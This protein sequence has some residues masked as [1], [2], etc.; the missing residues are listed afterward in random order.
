M[1]ASRI[2]KAVVCLLASAIAASPHDQ[3]VN[4]EFIRDVGVLYPNSNFTG[5]PFFLVQHKKAPRCETNSRGAALG[6]AQ[7]C[8]P[9]TCV[10]YKSKD[11]T[12]SEPGNDY[13]FH[14]P[15][16]IDNLQALP[17]IACDSYLCGPVEEMAE[18]IGNTA[19]AFANSEG[20]HWGVV[21]RF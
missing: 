4:N 17:D 19:S 15:V 5:D 7:I 2:S 20:G 6:S 3:M 13:Y 21:G 12:L 1:Y 18:M 11:C 16:D 9:S 10:F 14:G 8:V